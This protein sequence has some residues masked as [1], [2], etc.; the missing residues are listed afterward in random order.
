MHKHKSPASRSPSTRAFV[1]LAELIITKYFK[2]EVNGD[3]SVCVDERRPS[4][5][6]ITGDI[7]IYQ[8]HVIKRSW[9]YYSHWISALW[10]S[11]KELFLLPKLITV[12]PETRD[13][14]IKSCEYEVMT[15]VPSEV[16]YPIEPLE[17]GLPCWLVIHRFSNCSF[18]WNWAVQNWKSFSWIWENQ[19]LPYLFVFTAFGQVTVILLSSGKTL[20]SE[21][22]YQPSLFDKKFNNHA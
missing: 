9:R 14:E 20:D 18:C 17:W 3:L 1:S 5:L 11:A 2:Q 8:C 19:N 12:G 16:G 7:K 4:G 21:K 15:S 13:K 6:S 22:Q 10:T